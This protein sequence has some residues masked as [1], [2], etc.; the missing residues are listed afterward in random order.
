MLDVGAHVGPGVDDLKKLFPRPARPRHG[1]GH[2]DPRASASCDYPD[3]DADDIPPT[4][5]R[6]L[7]RARRCARS[8]S[9]RCCSSDR[10]IGA[11]WVGRACKGAFQRQASSRC[12]RRSPTRRSSRSRTRG[13][14]T[15]RARRSTSRRRPPRCCRRSAARRRL[16]AGVR[17]AHREAASGSS[18][19]QRL[20]F[21]SRTTD[22]FHLRRATAP[23]R[24]TS[25][26]C[27]R[28]PIPP[29]AGSLAGTRRYSRAQR[30]ADRGRGHR[31]DAARRD[32][33]ACARIGSSVRCSACRCS[34]KGSRSASLG[35]VARRAVRPFDGR[36]RSRCSAT[37]A[38]Q[39]VDRDRERAPVPRDP[40]QEPPARDREPAQ[41]R[42]PR[43]HV[44]RAAHAAQRDH[45]LLRG[46]ARADVRRAQREAGRLPEGHPLVRAG[47]CCSS[48]TT[49]STC[50]RSRP[51]AW[52]SSRRSSTCPPRIGNAMTLIRERAQRHGIAL[53][54]RRRPGARRDRRRRAQVQADPA[55]PAVQ[56]GEVHAR[57]R[58]GRR[59]PRA[60]LATTLEVAVRDTGIGI[61]H[62]GP[63]GGVRGVPPGRPALHEQAGRHRARPRADAPVRRAARRP[64]LARERARQ[65]LD[66][67]VHDSRPR[68]SEPSAP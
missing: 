65:G 58:P 14:S 63:G 5:A 6:R 36:A 7:P 9:R 52:S 18:H 50:R 46:A 32:R 59:Q 66:V 56:R 53:R 39:A 1:V 24:R 55:Q 12:S 26:T 16:D 38:D 25:S 62:G 3:L 33:G 4:L 40:G 20:V 61:A 60:A 31:P 29:G 37:F 2:R 15:R 49:S 57:R 19:G 47:T 8:S 17:Q 43:Q 54:H 21:I 22:L 51:A 67:H 34:G 48:S 23:R 68:R 28:N 64:H 27:A 41:E 35:A 13:C 42:V 11:L 45:R 44:A 30:R 10:A